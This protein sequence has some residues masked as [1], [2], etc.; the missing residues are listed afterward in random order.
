MYINKEPDNDGLYW[1][2]FL[3]DRNPGQFNG[4]GKLDHEATTPGLML[5]LSGEWKNDKRYGTQFCFTGFS[6]SRPIGREGIESF[7]MQ[8]PGLGKIL[9]NGIYETFR[10]EA[11]KIIIE[12]PER[13]SN[14]VAGLR[15]NVA[16]AA[17][18]FLG[19]IYSESK[20]KLQ[21]I[22]LFHGI[23]FPTN[24]P[25]L[26]MSRIHGDQVNEIKKNPFVLMRFHGVGF[27]KCD[28]LRLKLGLPAKLPER[29]EAACTQI[30]KDESD[31]IWLS[32]SEIKSKMTNLLEM[33]CPE[34]WM[35]ESLVREGEYYG[36]MERVEDEEFIAR[37]IAKRMKLGGNWPKVDG[38]SEHQ[39]EVIES[40]MKMR[41]MFLFGY[42][43]T[44]K[45]VRNG[46]PILTPSGWKNIEEIKLGDNVVSVNG[47]PT[48]VIGVYPQGKLDITRV[49][50]TDG[51]WIDTSLNHLWGVYDMQR[52]D[53]SR[54]IYNHKLKKLGD[55]RLGK[56][57]QYRIM[58][59]K[60]IFDSINKN[61]KYP[62]RFKIPMCLP[63]EFQKEELEIDPYTLGVILGDGGITKSVTI[64]T[65]D[66]EVIERIKLKYEVKEIKNKNNRCPGYSIN[67]LRQP[68]INLGLMWKKSIEKH[69]PI[70]YL[71]G[72]SCDRLNLL[73][74]LLDTDGYTDGKS[75]EYSTSSKQ[76][77]I[78]VTELVQSLGGIVS[79]SS[80]Y[81]TYTYNGE[82]RIGKKSYRMII[83]INGNPFFLPRKRNLYTPKTKYK[84]ARYFDRIEEV[85]IDYATCIKVSSESGLFIAKDHIVT[86]NTRTASQIVKAFQGSVVAI[87]PTGKAAKRL[88]EA[89]EKNGVKE[90]IPTTIHRALRPEYCGDGWKFNKDENNQI[91][92]DLVVIDECS[93]LNNSLASKLFRAIP[94][95]AHVLVVGDP[96]QLPPIGPGTLA[97]DM[98]EI[99]IGCGV[100][101]EIRRN[102][103]KIA[104]I[105]CKIRNGESFSIPLFIGANSESNLQ[106]LPSL[107]DA[108]SLAMLNRFIRLLL[109]GELDELV[110]DRLSD[111]QV[112]VPTH[113]N[114]LVG[115]IKL[116][117]HLQGIMNPSGGGTNERF[118]IGDKVICLENGFVENQYG[119]KFF[120][121]NGEMGK[122]IDATKRNVVVSMACGDSGLVFGNDGKLDLAYAISG[123]KFQ[124]SEADVIVAIFPFD[125]ASRM[126][127]SRQ[128]LYTALTRAKKLCVV[129]GSIGKLNEIAK[130]DRINKRRSFFGKYFMEELNE[131][132]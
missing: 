45:H 49:F 51:S 121:P 30:F 2:V 9:A 16:K 107:K 46:T 132:D 108:N 17:A 10:E 99:G 128:Y 101:T 50:F 120:V 119:E 92:A 5:E 65:P 60:E 109:G 11:I 86:H 81:P 78:D 58:S 131:K 32:E 115:R 52:L 54:R 44:G 55:K 33:Q 48:K 118:K 124:G 77:S 27:K 59:T 13:A 110:S 72:K 34:K 39:K 68:L 73:S 61:P 97:R 22:T 90:V 18:D 125:Y 83:K 96:A 21:L 20:S 104:E 112:L 66:K 19:K 88:G 117:K 130:D 95:E 57:G 75:I 28:L 123:H 87:A 14:E 82:K 6:R 47:L 67:S 69:I 62:H 31:Q 43:G 53:D 25:S 116:N 79:T 63:I 103:G 23:G 38:L 129:I 35:G 1:G 3:F 70:K 29:I 8:A 40:S 74:G 84:P 100:L 122:V 71:R 41:I 91:D 111:V 80:K 94:I 4:T 64:H 24:L 102:S 42:S 127:V 126:V 113:K 76:L 93:M 37:D 98:K 106:I 7:L 56:Y 26:V 12:D 36:L 105:G 15:L 89:L 114:E 85:G